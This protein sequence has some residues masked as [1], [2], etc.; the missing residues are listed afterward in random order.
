[1]VYTLTNVE[2]RQMLDFLVEMLPEGWE[3]DESYGLDFTLICPHGDVIEQDG[4]CPDGCVSP[5][6]TLGLI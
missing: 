2:R 5:M 4:R 1:M 6:I 3:L